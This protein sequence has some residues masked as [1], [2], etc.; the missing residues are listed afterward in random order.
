MPAIPVLVVGAGRMGQRIAAMMAQDSRFAVL[1]ATP[2]AEALAQAA[3]QGLATVLPRSSFR[4][5]LRA[6]LAKSRAVIL[7]DASIPPL[8]LARLASDN[9]S[10]YLDILEHTHA[11]DDL[12]KL[13]ADLPEQRLCFAPGCGLAPGHVTGLAAEALDSVGPQGEITVFVG[14]L[15]AH[16][17]NRLKYANIWSI[18][19]LV[20]EYSSPC[21][22]IRD[23]ELVSLPPLTETETVTLAG[24][25]YEAFT[26]AGSLDALARQHEGRVGSLVFKT[27][28]YQGHLDYIQFLLDDMG[29]SK[30]LYQLRSLLKATLPQ[31]EDDRVLIALR[32]RPGPGGAEH[33]T[34]QFLNATSQDGQRLSAIGTATASHVCAMT[35]LICTAPPQPGL[36]A[37]GTIGPRL[38]RA[39]PFFDLLDPARPS[40]GTA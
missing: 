12:A 22:A 20:G 28:R 27:L 23:G 35:D 26:T 13:L 1:I 16:P 14:V 17:T 11:S 15:P 5:D 32:V 34:C 24:N 7:T 9:G 19:G 39:S 6:Q 30:R 4:D 2:D 31:T 38:L 18:D 36:I 37:P 10:H 40:H 21:L 3:R 29:L 8:D 25:S 33:W